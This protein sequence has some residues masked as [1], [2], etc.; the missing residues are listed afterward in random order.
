MKTTLYPARKV[1]TMNPNRPLADCVA[2]RDGRILGTGSLEE[3]AR[4]GEHRV[5]TRFQHQVLMPGFVEGHCHLSQGALWRFVYVGPHD[6]VDPNGQTWPAVTTLAAVVARLK[7]AHDSAPHLPVVAWGFDPLSMQGPRCSRHDLD[8]VS[9]QQPVVLMHASLHVITTNTPGLRVGGYLRAGIDH[10]G[11]PLGPDGLPAGELRGPDAMWPV[12]EAAGL[13]RGLLAADEDGIG[14]FA[15]LCVRT[16]VTTAADLSNPLT[17]EIVAMM[18]RVTGAPD[19]PLRVV[20]MQRMAGQ[21]PVETVANAARLKDLSSD[22]L[23]LGFVKVVVDGSIQGLTARVQWPGYFNGADNGLWYVAPEQLCTL[24]SHA[25]GSKV[26]VHL[27]T[28]GDEATEL[29]LD[30]MQA[31]LSESPAFDHRCTLQHAQMSTPAQFLRMRS[32]GLC[33]NLFANHLY[34]WGDVHYAQTLGPERAERMNAC[35]S[36]IDAG[37]PFAIHSDAPVTPLAPLFT[38]W[39]AVNR[40]TAAGR[41]LGA[42][43]CI[44]VEQALH[45]ITLGAAYTLGLDAEIGSIEAGKRADF[46]VLNDDPLDGPPE[47]LKDIGVWGV[48]QGGRVFPADRPPPAAGPQD[49]TRDIH[50]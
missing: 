47:A 48:V 41:V 18:R 40:R 15:R 7:T 33:V 10:P 13:S 6:R 43:Q 4:W 23:R 26:P 9:D 46:A 8:T 16:G 2:V 30:C 24:L 3:L 5:D 19:F 1:I 35:A 28:N 44:G 50:S 21:G 17:D 12:A 14:V 45:A 39:C 37:V 36:A 49:G 22:R 29:A 25:L 31:A 20:S 38:A 42:A 27:H 34:Y 11:L 32:L